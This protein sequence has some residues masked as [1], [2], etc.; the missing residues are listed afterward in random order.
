[1]DDVK[2]LHYE[3]QGLHY[4]EK[5]LECYKLNEDPFDK[6]FEELRYEQAPDSELGFNKL[7]KLREN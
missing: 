6:H 5:I 2:E 3:H 7:F 1:M 4:I